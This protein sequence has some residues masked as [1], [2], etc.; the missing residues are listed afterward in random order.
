MR[1]LSCLEHKSI[2]I[3]RDRQPDESKYE[4]TESDSRQ[5]EK[6]IKYM[7]SGMVTWGRD[8]IKLSQY[9]G[10]LQ[11]NNLTIEILP[12]VYGSE[13]NKKKSSRD[14]LIRMLRD[15]GNLKLHRGSQANVQRHPYTVLDVFILAF[16]EELSEQVAKGLIRKYIEMEENLN[17][18]RGRLLIEKQ[19]KHNL[20]HK[21]RIHCLY[22]ELSIDTPMNQIIKFTLSKLLSLAR[23]VVVRKCVD[24][25]LIR[26][27]AVS[28]VRISNQTVFPVLD[29]TSARYKNIMDQC[30]LFIQNQY[31]DVVTGDQKAF[32]FLFDM[33][34]LFE[35]WIIAK[36]RPIV[37]KQGFKLRSQPIKYFG[38]W[39]GSESKKVSQMKPDF[40]LTGS[41]DKEISIGD[42]KWK[43][44]DQDKSKMNISENDLYQMQSYANRY[45][46][47]SLKLYYPKQEKLTSERLMKIQGR[48]ES[49]LKIIPVDITDQN[50]FEHSI[51]T[52]FYADEPLMT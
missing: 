35:R 14:A 9:C 50:F 51:H 24:E 48:H 44:L 8:S 6:L 31:P 3:V 33:N 22:D 13:A 11:V 34:K 36:L 18:L 12:K 43:I 1:I 38:V 25:L 15:C 52:E 42:A 39:D 10:V 49:E 17:V 46:V 30:K 21:E 5:I 26:F 16:C 4:I 41:N 7:P 2:G 28:D 45:E 29:Q 40:V 20:V 23:S 32:T 27:D 47:D 37:T 19:V